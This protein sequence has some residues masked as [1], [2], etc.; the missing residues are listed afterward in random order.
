MAVRNCEKCD[1]L[2]TI[3]SAYTCSFKDAYNKLRDEE[4]KDEEDEETCNIYIDTLVD[5]FIYATEI[6]EDK[7]FTLYEEALDS[8]DE[9]EE[10]EYDNERM[11]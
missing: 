8:L 6:I 5:I 1:I 11:C 4:N 9:L 10:L 3:Q 7:I 2:F